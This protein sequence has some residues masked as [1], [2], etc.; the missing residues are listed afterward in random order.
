MTPPRTGLAPSVTGARPAGRTPPA[1]SGRKRRRVAPGYLF[2]LPS[3]AILL[4]FVVYPI[5]Q[6][7]WM[8]LHDWS[9]FSSSHPFVGLANYRTM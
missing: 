4:V 2:L 1:R 3:A 6:S 7:F 9:F 5:A 8:S